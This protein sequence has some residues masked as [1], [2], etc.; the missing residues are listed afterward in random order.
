MSIRGVE[1]HYYAICRRKLWLFH[2]GIGFENDGHDR[3]ME[4]KILHERAYPK[5]E[6]DTAPEDFVRIDRSDDEFVREIKLTSSMEKAD[7][8]QMLYYLYLLKLK[9]VCKKGLL[10]YTKEKK[11][12]EVALDENEERE[13]KRALAGIDQV[14]R[15]TI[16]SFRKLPYCGKCAYRDFC[17]SG[18]VDANGT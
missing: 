17:F 3:V 16:P 13:V 6:R 18:E 12:V 15:G 2:K 1:M 9:G 10:S 7:R 11:V 8:L 4:G 5:M 14:I